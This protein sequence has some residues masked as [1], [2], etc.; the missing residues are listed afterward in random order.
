MVTA[1]RMDDNEDNTIMI[2]DQLSVT[3]AF[4]DNSQQE[5]EKVMTENMEAT[6]A[7]S[8]C[9]D[10]WAA[11]QAEQATAKEQFPPIT[12]PEA[13]LGSET[14]EG[15]METPLSVQKNSPES[16]LVDAFT[17]ERRESAV[18][19]VLPVPAQVT[20]YAEEVTSVSGGGLIFSSE[21]GEQ[22]EE[23][24]VL[25]ETSVSE[26]AEV[27]ETD[28][29]SC[30]TDASATQ[31]EAPCESSEPGE[32]ALSASSHLDSQTFPPNYIF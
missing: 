16:A 1:E 8:T 26:T 6:E 31:S 25:S 17:G 11:P 24:A 18:E 3:M 28:Q 30:D 10:T 14:Y 32:A 4:P 13:H 12:N 23:Q 9:E 15:N 2:K 22:T 21:A 20:G 29:E 7:P 19:I 27:I 5:G